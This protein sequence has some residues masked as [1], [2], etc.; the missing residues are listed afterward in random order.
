VICWAFLPANQ[1]WFETLVNPPGGDAVPPA[2]GIDVFG[3]PCVPDP[4]G[5]A[6]PEEPGPG[7]DPAGAGLTP[8]EAA[9]APALADTPRS[10]EL[11][12]EAVPEAGEFD[13]AATA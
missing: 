9:P 7:G 6:P 2:L 3:P 10:W 12:V 4:G 13:P 1:G 11:L 8:V 5:A